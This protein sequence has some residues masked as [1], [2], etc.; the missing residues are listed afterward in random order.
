MYPTLVFLFMRYQFGRIG[1]LM[2]PYTLLVLFCIVYMGQHWVIDGIVGAGYAVIV[3]AAVMKG[4]PALKAY[5]AKHPLSN[6]VESLVPAYPGA[7]R[8][9]DM[10]AADSRETG[11]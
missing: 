5:F 3:Y 7:T 10:V 2:V 1:Y 4:Y 11:R 9:E 6:P 8:S